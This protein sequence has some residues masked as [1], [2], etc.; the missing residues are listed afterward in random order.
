M[1][2]SISFMEDISLFEIYFQISC[3]HFWNTLTKFLL[4]LASEGAE[5]QGYLKKQAKSKALGK[6]MH[7]GGIN[8]FNFHPSARMV[9]LANMLENHV[10]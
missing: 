9:W 6:H 7:N 3:L 4:V 2:E 5:A 1:E 8:S 10:R